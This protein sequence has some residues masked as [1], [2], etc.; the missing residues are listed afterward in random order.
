MSIY[1]SGSDAFRDTTKWLVAFVPVVSIIAIGATVIPRLVKGSG[2]HSVS[3]W[4]GLNGLSLVGMLVSL[5][6]IALILIFGA[7]VLSS[8]PIG[9]TALIATPKDL[10]SAFSA[11]VGAPYFINEA[12]I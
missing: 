6:G 2:T 4:L 9:F 3:A 11:G 12:E 7:R 8:Q 5:V 1:D 10:S